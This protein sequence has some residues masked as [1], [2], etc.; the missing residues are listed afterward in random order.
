M[1]VVLLLMIPVM[2]FKK[3]GVEAHKP[4]ILGKAGGGVLLALALLMQGVFSGGLG[5]LVNMVLIGMLGMTA[6]EANLTKRWSQLILNFTVLL[7]VLTT[8]LIYWPILLVGVPAMLAG[9]YLGGHLAVKKGNQFIMN[10]MIALM[11]VSALGLIFG[12]GG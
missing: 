12:F 9:G 7:G 5:T 2:V 6:T 4:T 8:G 1:G 11:V 3:M 10:V